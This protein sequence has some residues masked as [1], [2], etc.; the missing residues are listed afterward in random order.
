MFVHYYIL[1]FHLLYIGISDARK[2]FRYVLN[3]YLYHLIGDMEEKLSCYDGTLGAK[4]IYLLIPY[5]FI[6][7][8][9]RY[10]KC[11]AFDAYDNVVGIIAFK[12]RGLMG[13]YQWIKFNVKNL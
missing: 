2:S 3:A 13:D 11:L 7:T 5:D 1:V 8:Y 10:F 12:S 9:L 4:K 6:M